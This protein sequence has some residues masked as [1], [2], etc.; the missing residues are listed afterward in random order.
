MKAA[1]VRNNGE[2]CRPS[3]QGNPEVFA[4]CQVSFWAPSTSHRSICRQLPTS[5]SITHST[6]VELLRESACPRTAAPTTGL[7]PLSLSNLLQSPSGARSLFM[8]AFTLGMASCGAVGGAARPAATGRASSGLAAP[9]A[10][11]AI[12]CGG[13]S[14]AVHRQRMAPRERSHV[15]AAIAGAPSEVLAAADGDRFDRQDWDAF[16]RGYKS[17]YEER[18]YWVEDDM[19][20]GTIPAELEGTL[21]RNGP[22]ARQSAAAGRQRVHLPAWCSASACRGACPHVLPPCSLTQRLGTGR[23]RQLRQLPLRPMATYALLPCLPC[24]PV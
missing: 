11:A 20:E 12:H 13:G 9:C 16:M 18:A 3:A 14:P 1:T 10:P 17:Q 2:C 21:L 8:Q 24:R 15:P 23:V 22:G 4:P 7:S 5:S 19:V 6:G